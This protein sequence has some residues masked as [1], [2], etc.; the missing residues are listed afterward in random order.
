MTDSTPTNQPLQLT[1]LIE[2][3][4]FV[5]PG[6]VTAGHIAA[7]IERSVDEVE[8]GLKDLE[9]A[10]EQGRGLRLQRHAGRV[11]LMSAPEAAPVLEKYL[12]LEMTTRLSRAALEA[13][14]IVAY[15]QPV[16]RPQLDAIRGVNSDGVL[17]SLLGK[18][19]IQE[20]G[21]S[22]AVGRPILY[23]TTA[24]FLQYFGLSSLQQLPPLDMDVETPDNGSAQKILK[25]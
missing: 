5:A 2:A 22:D 15:Q 8:T 4:L 24:E 18:G 7:A 9:S 17:K 19:L 13:L 25:D 23:G 16:T 1:A 14:A 6:P 10:Y 11:Q 20:A 12:G 3:I 21:R